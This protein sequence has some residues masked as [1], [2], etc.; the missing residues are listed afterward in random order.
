MNQETVHI[1]QDSTAKS[2]YR[3]KIW[4]TANTTPKAERIHHDMSGLISEWVSD[5]TFTTRLF[6]SPTDTPGWRFTVTGSGSQTPTPTR[7]RV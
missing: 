2:V 6:I 3:N 5:N 1:T 7:E 4:Y